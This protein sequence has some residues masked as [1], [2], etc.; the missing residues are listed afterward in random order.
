MSVSASGERPRSSKSSHL[1]LPS[2]T[3]NFISGSA[4]ARLS[5][6][7]QDATTDTALDDSPNESPKSKSASVI[8]SMIF[9]A[10]KASNNTQ[11]S[12]IGMI[13]RY[14]KDR[15]EAP[16]NIK[17]LLGSKLR[18]LVAQGKLT[19]VNVF[20]I[21][22]VLC[23]ITYF[24]AIHNQLENRY[25]ISNDSAYE[26]HNSLMEASET[27]A[28]KIAVAERKS[29]LAHEAVKEADRVSELAEETDCFLEIGKD[30]CERC[31]RGEAVYM[32]LT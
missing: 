4:P 13:V 26:W 7:T 14:I 6:P 10:L 1:A 18:R 22:F 24:T 32:N 19:K 27:A 16:H 29:F 8:N 21:N 17:R 5:T 11:G 3:N 20:F 30:I 28:Y 2:A 25:T 15:Y 23:R 9:D 12:D 31:S